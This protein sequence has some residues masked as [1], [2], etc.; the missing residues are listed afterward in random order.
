MWMDVFDGLLHDD[1]EL[2]YG[3]DW[4]L[5]FNYSQTSCV[6]KEERKRGWR[7]YCDIAFGSFYCPPC[8]R[9]WPSARV[10]VLFRF[11]LRAGRGTVLMRPFG[12]ACRLCDGEFALPGFSE[13]EARASLVRLFRKIGKFCYG[14]VDDDDYGGED[15]QRSERRTKPHEA[16][17]CEACSQ[18]ICNQTED[19]DGVHG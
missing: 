9:T 7:V 11:R 1:N 19:D 13:A 4:C 15:G 2:D 10:T 18:G 16:D 12:Q 5:N 3:D 6:T 14:E 17:L 8:D